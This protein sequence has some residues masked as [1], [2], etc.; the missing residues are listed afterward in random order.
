MGRPKKP[1]GQARHIVIAGKV[2]KEVADALQE[3]MHTLNL[4]SQ[5]EALNLALCSWL[6]IGGEVDTLFREAEG[7][8]RLL[9]RNKREPLAVEVVKPMPGEKRK[10]KPKP[11]I[12]FKRFRGLGQFYG[13]RQDGSGEC[14]WSSVRG[15]PGGVWELWESPGS[16][17]WSQAAYEEM[18]RLSLLPD[19]PALKGPMPRRK[20]SIQ[21]PVGTLGDKGKRKRKSKGEL[22][23]EWAAHPDNPGTLAG[24][25]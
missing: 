11:R 21:S 20:P 9:V 7:K 25:L 3:R 2:S 19:P 1:E 10:G 24:I 17:D 18:A 15:V 23:A 8:A 6:G 4:R 5:S 13:P 22:A 12:D 16:A 14:V